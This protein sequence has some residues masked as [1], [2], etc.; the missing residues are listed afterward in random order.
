M[1][2]DFNDPT[3]RQF[4]RSQQATKMYK[5]DPKGA[6]KVVSAEARNTARFNAEDAERKRTRAGMTNPVKVRKKSTG[7]RR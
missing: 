1:P 6:L 5:T 4:Y 2:Q 7:K 3:V